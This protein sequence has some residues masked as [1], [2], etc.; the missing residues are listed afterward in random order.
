MSMVCLCCNHV[1]AQWAMLP[2]GTMEMSE[3]QAAS[4]GLARVH[5]PTVDGF[6]VCGVTRNLAKA[7]SMLLLAAKSKEAPLAVILMTLDTVEEGG[8]GGLL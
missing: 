1:D 7:P 8:R 4:E 6:A 2:P 3:V 5:D